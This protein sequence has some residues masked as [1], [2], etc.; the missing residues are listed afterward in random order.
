MDPIITVL[1]LNGD[2]TDGSS[3]SAAISADLSSLSINMS[4]FNRPAASGS[5]VGYDTIEVTFPDDRKYTGQLLTPNKIRWSNN[6]E[7]TKI[8]NTVMDLNGNWS[9]GSDR[10]AVIYEGAKSI[11]INM[12]DYDRPNAQG[13]IVNSSNIKV[14][15]PDDKEYTA[16]LIAPNKIKW[17][18][19]SF[20]TKKT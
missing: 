10:T 6:S 19:G 3:R 20:W 8:V 4:A 9:D 2:W 12:S 14:K 13:T 15:F 1:N 18:N 16:Q 11:K 7:W 5:I 17:S